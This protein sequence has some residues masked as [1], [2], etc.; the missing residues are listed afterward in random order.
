MSGQKHY[1]RGSI[2][3]FVWLRFWLIDTPAWR[4]LSCNARVLY[5]Q[6]ARKYNG[7]NNGRIS[8]SVREA[9]QE[10][11]I[12]KTA[13]VGAFQALQ[14]RGFIVCTKKGA[15]S[16]KTVCEASDWRLTEY[17][18]HFPPEH[19]SKE[20]M[21]WQPP[22]PDS[23]E[24]PKS[25]TRV[26]KRDRTGPETRPHRFSG[27]TM[28]AKKGLHGFSN[29]TTNTEIDRFIGPETRHLYLPGT[30][31]EGGER[32][33]PK[34][35]AVASEPPDWRTL[36]YPPG[37]PSREEHL[38]ALERAALERGRLRPPRRAGGRN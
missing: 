23:N 31:P 28:S 9:S 26:L 6:L 34:G 7:R 36:A 29:E 38:A 16:W 21:R 25:R 20:F 27:E 33:A 11:N 10:L 24:A 30:S 4:S 19:A 14:D 17:D 8:Y 13:A 32:S 2:P 1:K 37:A 22:E 35:S 12:G 15:F 18:N 5:V 3:R